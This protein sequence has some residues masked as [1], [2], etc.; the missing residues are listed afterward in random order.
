M[1][2]RQLHLTIIKDFISF[3]NSK[4]NKYVLKGGTALMLLYN[5]DRFSEDI[6]LDSTDPKFFTYVELFINTFKH[7]YKGL[8]YR[9]GKDT[10]TVKRAFIHY[11]GSK[12]LKVEVSYRN[13]TINTNLICSINNIIT[14]NINTLMMLKL[15]A[16]TGRDKIRDLYDI[17]FI[18]LTYSNYLQELVV[19]SLKTALMY[20]GIEYFDYLIKTQSDELID[21]NLLMQRFLTIWYS[22]GLT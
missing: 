3:L 17:C 11:G 2:W 14:Y 4:S 20:K 18:Y 5:L 13:K 19:E 16:F 7:K 15:Q 22:L 10:D 12:P 6:D 21:N 8:T 9:K 1:S